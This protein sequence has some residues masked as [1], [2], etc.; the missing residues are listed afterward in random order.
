[1]SMP[2]DWVG[3]KPA[4]V[5]DWE[6]IIRERAENIVGT[7]AVRLRQVAD[8]WF[9][10]AARKIGGQVGVF[11]VGAPIQFDPKPSFDFRWHITESLT[12]AGKPVIGVDTLQGGPP[13]T[14]EREKVIRA[15]VNETRESQ[16]L[17]ESLGIKYD[18]QVVTDLLA[19]VDRLRAK[20]QRAAHARDLAGTA[21]A[22]LR[23]AC[24][25]VSPRSAKFRKAT[26]PPRNE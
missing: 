5:D 16:P 24:D 17:R 1:M 8:G 14:S 22:D 25:D 9:V 2:I 6:K 21:A 23:D 26:T 20:L 4:D 11:P 18:V 7:G 19:E 12:K 10:E 15:S 13:L 3:D